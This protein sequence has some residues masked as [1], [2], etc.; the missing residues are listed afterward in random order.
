[1]RRAAPT[2]RRRSNLPW[3]RLFTRGA[4]ACRHGHIDSTPPRH[5]K[6]MARIDYDDDDDPARRFFPH[7]HTAPPRRV[8]SLL[9]PLSLPLLVD[10]PVA[11]RAVRLGRRDCRSD[12]VALVVPDAIVV[13]G[14]RLDHRRRFARRTDR[15]FKFH[16]EGVLAR[17]RRAEKPPLARALPRPRRFAEPP[18]ARM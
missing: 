1:M 14:I 7:P 10:V 8:M 6:D 17:G 4:S 9:Q 12:R 18:G 3:R 15:K 13:L 16:V 11:T 2:Q 5:G